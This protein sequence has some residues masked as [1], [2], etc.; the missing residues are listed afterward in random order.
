MAKQQAAAA[1]EHS[2]TFRG[3]TIGARELTI[4]DDQRLSALFDRLPDGGTVTAKYTFAEYMIGHVLVDGAAP[5]PVVD[6]HSSD[7]EIADAWAAWQQQPRTL[8]S[9]WRATVDAMEAEE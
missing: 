4:S 6:E 1:A 5:V 2:F 9:R 8:S 3:A 7:D